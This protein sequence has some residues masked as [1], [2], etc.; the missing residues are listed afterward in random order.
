MTVLLVAEPQPLWL[1]L[2]HTPPSVGIAHAPAEIGG[3]LHEAA[4]ILAEVAD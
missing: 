1:S 2:R 3:T 4:G